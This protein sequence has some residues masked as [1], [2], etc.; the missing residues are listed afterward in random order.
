MARWEPNAVGRLREAALDLFRDRGYDETTV[1]EIAERAG[2]TPRTF[3]RYF[4]DKREVLFAGAEKLAALLA[5]QVAAEPPR[6]T[7]IDAVAHAL[8]AVA[9]ASAESA[10]FFRRRQALIKEH[11]EL[12]E[13][14][15]IKHAAL[16]TSIAEALRR[17]G[18]PDPS[19]SLAAEA[20]IASF[21]LAFDTWACDSKRRGLDHHV[22]DALSGLKQ[23]VGGERVVKRKK[24]DWPEP[25]A[26]GSQL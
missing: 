10:D 17:R 8:E 26:T 2:V 24:R 6:T 20:G 19:A 5:E 21:K 12:R 15:L 9:A 14:D 13:R 18:V 1:A 22:R 25:A 11:A 3:F 4:A 23:V 7:A 16:A